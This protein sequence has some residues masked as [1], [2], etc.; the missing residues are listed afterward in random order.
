MVDIRVMMR[1]YRWSQSISAE[2][3]GQGAGHWGTHNGLSK[4][5]KEIFH[6]SGLQQEGQRAGLENEGELRPLFPHALST[7]H[8]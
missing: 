2:G 6:P 1:A 4:V 7:Q 3:R 5:A 8:V